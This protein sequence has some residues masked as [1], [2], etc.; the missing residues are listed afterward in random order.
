L[1]GWILDLIFG[2]KMEKLFFDNLNSKFKK[3]K[4]QK[5]ASDHKEFLYITM[6]FVG[7]MFPI[8]KLFGEKKFSLSIEN[9]KY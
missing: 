6:A 4:E 7:W 8:W 1:S 2:M 9:R 3:Q 5:Y